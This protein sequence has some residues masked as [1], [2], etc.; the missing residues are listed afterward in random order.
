VSVGD[1]VA[2]WEEVVEPNV[3]SVR[4]ASVVNQ[5]DPH[6]L[7]LDG[8]PDRKRPAELPVV[9]IALHGNYRAEEL[10]IN[11]DRRGREVACVEDR[12]G[13][14]EEPQ[15]LRRKGTRAAWKMRVSQERDQ[16]RSSRNSPF[17]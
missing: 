15:A 1:Q 12:V 7:E 16:M 13:C 10:Q 2:S 4:R 8:R 5:A 14:V 17:R 9:H 11:K 6:P 3:P